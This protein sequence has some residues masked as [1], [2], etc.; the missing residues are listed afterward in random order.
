MRDFIIALLAI[1]LGA[2]LTV[3]LLNRMLASEAAPS[4]PAAAIQF[5]V[6]SARQWL[7]EDRD[8]VIEQARGRAVLGPDRSDPRWSPHGGRSAR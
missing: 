3:R 7:H 5:R 8:K 1:A 4:Q 6:G 2:F